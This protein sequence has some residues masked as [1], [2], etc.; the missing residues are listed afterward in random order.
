MNG[1][2]SEMTVRID[3]IVDSNLME[4]ATIRDQQ[5]PVKFGFS[6][7]IHKGLNCLES[8]KQ[9]TSCHVNL[10]FFRASEFTLSYQEQEE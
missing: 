8:D 5:F 6:Q 7:E 4:F 2:E 10:C 1:N 9:N 3:I